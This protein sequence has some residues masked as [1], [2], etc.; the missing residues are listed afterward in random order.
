MMEN[1]KPVLDASPPCTAHGQHIDEVSSTF[2]LAKWLQVSLLL[3]SGLGHSCHHPS[4]KKIPLSELENDPSALHNHRQKLETR[5][6]MMLGE[7]PKECDYC[8]NI[9]D[10]G[11]R[12]DRYYKSE[13]FW[14]APFL[15]DVKSIGH[16]GTIAPK[17][18]EVSFSHNCNFKCAYCGPQ[19]SSRWI[20]EAEK[21]GPYPT[22]MNYGDISWLKSEGHLPYAF[23]EQNP[24]VKAFWH[25][26]PE[27]KPN[28]DVFRITGGE[29]LMSAAT[30]KV[31]EDLELHPQPN[32]RFAIN[33]NLGV[34]QA[35]VDRLINKINSLNGNIKNFTLFTSV[36]TGIPEHAEYLRFGMDFKLFKRNVEIILEKVTWRIRLTMICTVN[37]LSI[38]GLRELF[39]WNYSLRE[40]FPEKS[41]GIDT[42]YLRYPNFLALPVLEPIKI[43][44]L[45][46]CLTFIRPRI[47]SGSTGS[48]KVVDWM[49][50]SFV[51]F[52]KREYDRLER[53]MHWGVDE[54]QH[55]RKDKKQLSLIKDDFQK[56]LT[57]YDKRRNLNHRAVFKDIGFS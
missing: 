45:K 36:D 47:W 15:E 33:S 46:N 5:R 56:F 26:W 48:T 13:E 17:Y 49:E 21:F 55:I 54:S 11:G 20:E 38:E 37:A 34:A 24:Y 1:F 3:Q 31:L 44:G 4:P 10:S 9:E 57:E 2:C 39:Q 25:W 12:S 19:S 32:L 8:W 6:L 51:G 14:A 53:V 43:K 52:E 27:I 7:R 29:P 22:S 28:L 18:L 23:E 30:W 35:K 42:P 50:T 16:K 41:I 40:R